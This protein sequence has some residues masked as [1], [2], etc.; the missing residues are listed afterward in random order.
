M[1]VILF[2][3]FVST[4]IRSNVIYFY[5]V[6][7]NL[8][9]IFAIMASSVVATADI[10]FDPLLQ[11]LLRFKYV[12]IKDTFS[13]IFFD[14]F[15]SVIFSLSLFLIPRLSLSTTF[16]LPLVRE[17]LSLSYVCPPRR[18]VITT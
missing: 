16:S 15:L 17:P 6:L 8:N 4:V 7:H 5:N 14:I 10:L 3:E 2:S 18:A 9:Y 13:Y 1:P 11:I 12:P